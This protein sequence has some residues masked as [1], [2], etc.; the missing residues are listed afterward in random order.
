MDKPT[1]NAES[2]IPETLAKRVF[3]FTMLAAI[4]YVGAVIALMSTVQ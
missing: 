2:T 3:V 4:V 1:A